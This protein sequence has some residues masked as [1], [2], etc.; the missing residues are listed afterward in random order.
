MVDVGIG[1]ELMAAGDARRMMRTDPRRVEILDRYGKRRWDPM[2]EGIDYIVRPDEHGDFQKLVN[3]PSARP[4]LIAKDRKRRRF[5]LAYRAMP[6]EL[7]LTSAEVAFAAQYSDR[8]ILEPHVKPEAPPGK[9]WGWV[10]WSKLAAQLIEHG[11]RVTQLGPAGTRSLAG[12]ELIETPTFRHAAAVLAVA[13]A[14]VFP[15]GG[16]HHAAAA[17]GLPAVVIFGGYTPVEVTGYGIHINL[18]ASG[19]DACGMRVRCK[20]CE[21]WMANIT[22]EQVMR[23]L[24]KFIER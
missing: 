17:V 20:H 16:L 21:T 1:D 24:S 4:Y 11:H 13:R 19:A 15:E 2:W 9:Q 10:R 12:A 22:T 18:G 6:A 3:G 5:N 7:K 14:A 8:I 23:E